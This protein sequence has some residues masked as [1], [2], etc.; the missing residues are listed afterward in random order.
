[1]LSGEFDQLQTIFKHGALVTCCGR[2]P[3]KDQGLVDDHAYTITG[4]AELAISSSQEVASLVRLRNPWADHIEW[5]G[6]WSDRYR[7][8]QTRL[9]TSSDL[10]V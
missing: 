3:K 6:P 5:T 9:S 1:M 8:L 7:K 10:P 4:V 2:N